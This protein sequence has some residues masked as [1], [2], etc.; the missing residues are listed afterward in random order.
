MNEDGF[1]DPNNMV[2]FPNVVF[3]GNLYAGTGN[4]VT[5]GE[6]WRGELTGDVEESTEPL[7]DV[8]TLGQNHPNPFNAGIS[9]RYALPQEGFV[10]LTI[11]NVSGQKVRT[12]VDETK[13]VGEHTVSWNSLDEAGNEVATGVYFYKFQVGDYT[14][15]KKMILVR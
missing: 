8:Y 4:E 10:T 7:S 11:Y 14:E 12:L 6:I 13:Q 3:G 5:G 2:L 1:G 15:T 9:I